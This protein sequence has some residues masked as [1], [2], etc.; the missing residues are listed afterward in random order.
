MYV[1]S[2]F[3]RTLVRLHVLFGGFRPSALIRPTTI[4]I[5]D[6]GLKCAESLEGGMCFLLYS[7]YFRWLSDGQLIFSNSMYPAFL[8]PNIESTISLQCV[9]YSVRFMKLGPCTS[10]ELM[11]YDN[12]K[13]IP[14]FPLSPCKCP[15]PT[16][17]QL[18]FLPFSFP[19]YIILH[20]ASGPS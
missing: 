9:I 15:H 6:S 7:A 13:R 12:N 3:F 4:S 16:R 17:H 14:H 19:V 10:S 20:T 1:F 8:F 5:A 18:L 11:P 2:F